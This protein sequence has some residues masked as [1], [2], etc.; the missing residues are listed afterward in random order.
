MSEKE[1]TLEVRGMSC[2]ACVRHVENALR[3][4]AGVANVRVD[5]AAASA[6]IEH[7]HASPKLSDLID[8]LTDAGYEA[9]AT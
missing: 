6:T 1:T 7:A 3:G 9:K 4:V 5:L 2:S 8:A